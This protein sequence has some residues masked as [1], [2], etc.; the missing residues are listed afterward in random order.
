MSHENEKHVIQ[1]MPCHPERSEGAG[2]RSSEMLSA[3]KH[4]KAAAQ[5]KLAEKRT[6]LLMLIF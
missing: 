2:S 6:T 3:A 4:D 1:H 5:K